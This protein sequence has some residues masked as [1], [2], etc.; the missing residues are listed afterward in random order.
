MSAFI[1]EGCRERAVSRRWPGLR[2]D[3]GSPILVCLIVNSR[4]NAGPANMYDIN[5]TC[6]DTVLTMSCTDTVC[7]TTTFKSSRAPST[8]TALVTSNLANLYSHT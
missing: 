2:A 5:C 6:I 7:D 8:D 1:E 3:G 4:I